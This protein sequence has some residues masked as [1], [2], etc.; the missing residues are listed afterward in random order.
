MTHRKASTRFDLPQP[1]GP[2]DAGE[3]GQDLELGRLDEALEAD[4]AQLA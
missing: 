4:E 3:A 1:V 2:D